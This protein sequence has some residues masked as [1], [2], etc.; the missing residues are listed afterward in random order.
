MSKRD[1]KRDSA[2]KSQDPDAESSFQSDAVKAFVA[3]VEACKDDAEDSKGD[4]IEFLRPQL[5]RLDQ[6]LHESQAQMEDRVNELGGLV[7]RKSLDL[8][9]L[10]KQRDRQREQLPLE[11]RERF[12][13]EMFRVADAI[14][15]AVDS[16]TGADESV[17]EGV[18]SISRLMDNAM[19]SQG[20][21]KI[22]ALHRQYD[23][24]RHL[25]IGDT[26]SN[27]HTAGTVITVLQSGYI[28]ELTGNVL[29]PARVIVAKNPPTDTENRGTCAES[30]GDSDQ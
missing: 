8:N 2:H 5:E 3:A 20:F 19:Q 12:A 30:D 28:N 27:E 14:D 15:A 13:T 16:L 25:W 6:E 21:L 26:E 11:A 22:D 18:R 24:S 7:N 10:I 29:R 4:L 17:L 23:A 1:D 9:E